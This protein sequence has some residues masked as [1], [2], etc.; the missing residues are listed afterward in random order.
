MT[1]YSPIK[2]YR[3]KRKNPTTGK[4]SI[5]FNPNLGFIDLPVELPCGQCIGCRLER[6]RQWAIR[7]VHEASLFENNCFIT[8]TYDNEHLPSDKGLHV[9]EFQKFMKR[10]RKSQKGMEPVEDNGKIRYP[11]RFFHCGEYGEQCLNCGLSKKLC[12]CESFVK[13]IGRPH[14]HACLFN[15]DFKDKELLRISKNGDEYYASKTLEKLWPKGISLIGDV[16]FESAAY[17]ARYITKKVN[18][19]KKEGHYERYDTECAGEG[20]EVHSEYTTCSRRPGVGYAWYQ[21][22]RDETYRDDF[23]I[24]R[25]RKVRPPKAYDKIFQ[26]EKVREALRTKAVRKIKARKH[27]KDTTPE[28]LLDREFCQMEKFKKLKRGMEK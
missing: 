8:L 20:V 4:R 7:C 28:R 15:F 2:G 21:K 6:S 12:K 10:L 19:P 3:S 17:V 5:V 26:Q 27:E 13:Q 11:I 14:F 25:G 23:V 24:C 22:Y 1:C 9:S 16:T 18:G